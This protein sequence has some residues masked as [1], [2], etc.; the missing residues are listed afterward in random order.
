MT[1]IYSLWRQGRLFIFLLCVLSLTLSCHP[2]GKRCGGLGII[3]NPVLETWFSLWWLWLAIPFH[4]AKLRSI[5]FNYYT[6]KLS[7]CKYKGHFLLLKKEMCSM[8][9]VREKDPLNKCAGKGM[10]SGRHRFLSGE[11]VGTSGGA[12]Q[13]HSCHSQAEG[14]RQTTVNNKRQVWWLPTSQ[15][16]SGVAYWK[17][18]RRITNSL[19]L[20][21]AA[22]THTA[23]GGVRRLLG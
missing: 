10:G 18:N 3:K 1:R 15:E 19:G 22:H 12:L 20:C 13:S 8:A 23:R 14:F 6:F 11:Q 17:Q 21:K 4:R 16:L 7:A 2:C 9:S 5:Y